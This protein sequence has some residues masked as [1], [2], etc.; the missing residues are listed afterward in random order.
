MIIHGG[1]IY[2]VDSTK[3]TVEAVVTKNEIILFAGSFE[4]AKNYQNEQTEIIDLKGTTMTPGLIEGHG[5]F[6]G[7][8]YN[9]LE[10]DLMNTS[11]YQD[12]IDAVA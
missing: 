1:T 8:G 12:I 4:E 6:M 10:L 2:T 5:H 7:L 9:E 3:T 11:S